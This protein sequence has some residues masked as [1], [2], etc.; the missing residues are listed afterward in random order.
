[1]FGSDQVAMVKAGEDTD[2]LPEMLED[3]DQDDDACRECEGGNFSSSWCIVEG[4]A[5]DW[6]GK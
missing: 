4:H 3:D 2:S 1:M 6:P 5:K